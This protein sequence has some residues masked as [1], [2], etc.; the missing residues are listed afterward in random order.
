MLH[1]L[2]EPAAALAA[3]M[4]ELS[5]AAYCAAWM[6]DNEYVLWSAVTSGPRPYGQIWILPEHIQRLRDLSTLAGGWIYFDDEHEQS[7]IALDDW[8]AR[9]AVHTADMTD[10]KLP[11]S[12]HCRC[13]RIRMRVT[14]PPLLTMAC[15][16]A[17]CQR[18]TASAYSLSVAIPTDGF[19]VEG[20]PVIG[21]MHGASRHYHCPHCKSWLFTRPEGMDEL[22][23]VRA[24]MLDEHAWY[25]P[26]VETCTAE[27][28]AWAKTGAAHSFPNIPP[29]GAFAPLIAEFA[30]KGPRP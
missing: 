4:S 15:H 26:Y 12:A 30:A 22:V 14:K 28:Y 21:G 10:W 7:W 17:G 19:E 25:A 23:N 8:E 9:F 11:W 13:E 29:G 6:L 27:G 24:S 5:E 1:D 3:Y 2:D 18:M 16:C 20:E